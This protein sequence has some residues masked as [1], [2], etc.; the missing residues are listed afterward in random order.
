MNTNTPK[1]SQSQMLEAVSKATIN[2]TEAKVLRD[3]KP[4]TEK[5]IPKGFQVELQLGNVYVARK[6][7]EKKWSIEMK[8]GS[9]FLKDIC[10][11]SASSLP[12]VCY[13]IKG[14]DQEGNF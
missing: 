6:V 5:K 14:F 3:M 11:K 10:P 8:D 12:E 13:S 4:K 2:L 9:E 1:V 7:D